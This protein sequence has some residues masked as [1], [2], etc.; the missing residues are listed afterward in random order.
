MTKTRAAARPHP[1]PRRRPGLLPAL[2]RAALSLLLLALL[3]VALPAGLLYGTLTLAGSSPLPVHESIPTLLTSPDQG[4]LFAWALVGVGWIAWACFAVSVVVEIPAQLRGRI[5]R[6]LPALG[7]SQRTAA[8]LIGAIFALLPATGAFAATTVPATHAPTAATAPARADDE[9]RNDADLAG[10]PLA[11]EGVVPG[12]LSGGHGAAGGGHRGRPGRVPR[13]L[14][15]HAVDRA[16]PPRRDDQRDQHDEDRHQHRRLDRDRTA[17]AA[18]T[19]AAHGSHASFGLVT[20]V[21]I[22]AP[23]TNGSTDCAWT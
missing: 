21:V 13:G 22:Q 18:A 8:G 10:Q 1:L 17:L 23:G 2:L 11:A 9:V 3:L 15:H 12:A 19:S 6:R 14:D 4:G 5:P 7:W 16:D 20:P